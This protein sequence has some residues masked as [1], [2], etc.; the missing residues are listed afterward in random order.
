MDLGGFGLRFSIIFDSIFAS[1]VHVWTP[2]KLTTVPWFGL[3]VQGGGLRF[4]WFLHYCCVSFS[5]ALFDLFVTRFLS[6]FGIYFASKVDAFVYICLHVFLFVWTIFFIKQTH[7][8]G[9]TKKGRRQGN[10]YSGDLVK[11]HIFKKLYQKRG[12][13]DF[14]HKWVKTGPLGKGQ[15]VR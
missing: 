3:I 7:F 12:S 13:V 11:H 8:Q 5:R 4:R 2:R 14:F 10:Y 6:D 15:G 1:S 9:V